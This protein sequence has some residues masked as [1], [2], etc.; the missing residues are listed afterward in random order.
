M[1]DYYFGYPFGCI[2]NSMN[3]TSIEAEKVSE[4][5][6]YRLNP[7]LMVYCKKGS[8][9]YT[10]GEDM[11]VFSDDEL[12]YG[13]NINDVYYISSRDISNGESVVSKEDAAI[14]VKNTNKTVKASALKKAAIVFNLGASVN[15]GGKLSYKK[16]SGSKNLSVNG[17]TGKITVKKKT[18]KGIYNIKIQISA[19]PAGTY[20]AVTR[21]V[22]IK[23]K[24]K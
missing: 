19:D 12:E 7:E 20:K 23:V 18:K 21:T 13:L 9:V 16:I 11:S 6:Y 2:D 22:V 14:T 17:G 5:L 15:S 3:C 8:W 24:V 1:E 4:R 10:L